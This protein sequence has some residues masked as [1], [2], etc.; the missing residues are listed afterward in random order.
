MFTLYEVLGMAFLAGVVILM[1]FLHIKE[2]KTSRTWAK[3][4]RHYDQHVRNRLHK[5]LDELAPERY[6]EVVDIAEKEWEEAHRRPDSVID[7]TSPKIPAR[8]PDLWPHSGKL[9]GN[10]KLSNVVDQQRSSPKAPHNATVNVATT[11][12]VTQAPVTAS[13]VRT[14]KYADDGWGSSRSLQPLVVHRSARANHSTGH[15]CVTWTQMRQNRKFLDAR[16]P[17]PRY[18]LAAASAFQMLGK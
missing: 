18:Y 9:R 3:K 12:P 1:Q 8:I 14:V 4:A 13:Q 15:R 6:E 16:H 5:A 10:H 7:F 17:V 2:L 11:P